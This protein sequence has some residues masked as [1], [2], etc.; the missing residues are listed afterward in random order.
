[1]KRHTPAFCALIAESVSFQNQLSVRIKPRV[2]IGRLNI[3]RT[4]R[5]SAIINEIQQAVLTI[6]AIGLIL[7]EEDRED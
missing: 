5:E 2:K 6:N 1:M 4:R 7:E 3:Y